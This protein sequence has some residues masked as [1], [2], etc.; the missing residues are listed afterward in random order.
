MLCREVYG[1]KERNTTEPHALDGRKVIAQKALKF[2]ESGQ[3]DSVEEA[4]MGS[5]AKSD[6]LGASISN[7]STTESLHLHLVK[8]RSS[9]PWQASRRP[10]ISE[11]VVKT[12]SCRVMLVSRAKAVGKAARNDAKRRPYSP[13][14]TSY[15]CSP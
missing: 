4:V 12:N 15:I 6:E 7:F 10:A 14:S 2:R 11:L 1:T 5:K 3:L 13:N 9:R 8:E